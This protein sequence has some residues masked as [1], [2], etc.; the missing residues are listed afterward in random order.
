M[1]PMFTKEELHGFLV[2]CARKG[3]A[4][5]AVVKEKRDDGATVIRLSQGRWSMED[6]YYGGEPYSGLMAVKCDGVGVWTMVYYGEVFPGIED[7]PAVYAVLRHALKEVPEE[8]PFRGPRTFREG[9]MTYDNQWVGSMERFK[10]HE[11][12]FTLNDGGK[13]CATYMGGLVN[14]RN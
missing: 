8:A 1:R 5:E 13:Y 12:I 2:Y 11:R 6:V 9:D 10:G 7:V 14:Q 4:D 3:Y